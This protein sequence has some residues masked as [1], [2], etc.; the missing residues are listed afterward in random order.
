MKNSSVLLLVS[1]DQDLANLLQ[2]QLSTSVEVIHVKNGAEALM[3]CFEILP[4]VIVSDYQLAGTNG[5]KLC[6]AIKFDIRTRHIPFVL[7]H[8]K[9]VN[10]ETITGIET[11]PDYSLKQPY[12]IDDIV[13]VIQQTNIINTKQHSQQIISDY[14]RNQ[15][16]T[17][18]QSVLKQLQT[19]IEEEL[20]NHAFSVEEFAEEMHMSRMQ[21]YRFTKK[22]FS[23]SPNQ[24]LKKRRLSKAKQLLESQSKSIASVAD[25][26]GFSQPAYFSKCFKEEFNCSP[27][28]YQLK[29]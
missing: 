13:Q 21:L 4:D 26:C 8:D 14:K 17:E 19:I 20:S 2:K 11:G 24:L 27:K 6:N 3:K 7:L 18:E 12:S 9:Y 25:D 29:A 22:I 16:T 5:L 23:L 1:S 15:L 28:E 10:A